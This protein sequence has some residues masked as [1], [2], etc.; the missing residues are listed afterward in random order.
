MQKKEGFSVLRAGQIA[1][2]IGFGVLP[3]FAGAQELPR[4]VRA[5]HWAASAVQNALSNGLLSLGSDKL[6]HG[7]A[8]VTHTQTV[9]ALARLGHALEEHSWKSHPSQALTDKVM[10]PLLK[11]DWRKLPVTRYTFAYVVTRYADYLSNGLPPADTAADKGKSAALPPA[12]SVSIADSHPAHAALVYLTSAR[13]LWAKSA[14]LKPD[15]QPLKGSELSQALSQ[16]AAGVTDR[17]TSLGFDA[18]GSTP[19][20]SF[21]KEPTKKNPPPPPSN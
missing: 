11:G 6:F 17:Q 4:D 18:N 13:M 15:D 10:A 9:I 14:L 2:A 19:D 3:L 8:K 5:N 7:E 20:A 1:L 12:A 16:L 21:H